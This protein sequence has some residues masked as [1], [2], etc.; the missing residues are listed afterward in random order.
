MVAHVE[1]LEGGAR[2]ARGFSAFE[3]DQLAEALVVLPACTGAGVIHGDRVVGHRADTIG[4]APLRRIGIPL[5]NLAW[6]RQCV[7]CLYLGPRLVQNGSMV[8]IGIAAGAHNRHPVHPALDTQ[9]V[10]PTVKRNLVIAEH[11]FLPVTGSTHAHDAHPV[12]RPVHR[13]NP[14]V[15]PH[16]GMIGGEVR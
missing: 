16:C 3:C 10:C 1:D 11:D 15:L 4:S 14:L 7:E 12:A 8:V 2:L 13:A 9:L 5:D 6:I